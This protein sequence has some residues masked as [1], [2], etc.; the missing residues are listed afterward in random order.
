MLL[1]CW[2]SCWLS[3]CYHVVVVAVDFVD[4]V[5]FVA[6][7]PTLQPPLLS[8]MH[9]SH[10]RHHQLHTAAALATDAIAL[11][12]MIAAAIS[13]ASIVP[14]A[15]VVSAAVSATAAKSPTRNGNCHCRGCRLCGVDILSFNKSCCCCCCCCCC[16]YYH[17]TIKV[18]IIMLTNDTSFWP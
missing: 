15:V 7:L 13:L 12:A 2:L 18:N 9:R 10:C 6:G 14:A 16:C 1:L 5:D 17:A 4:F 3:C 11:A 8:P